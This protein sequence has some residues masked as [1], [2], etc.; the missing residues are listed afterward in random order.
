V[1]KSRIIFL[2]PYNPHDVRK[3]SGT[4]YSLYRA[5]ST[6]ADAADFKLEYVS[7]GVLDFGARLINKLVQPW[8]EFDCR[9]STAYAVVSGIYLT[10]R[11]AL[12]RDGIIVAVAASNYLPYITTRKKILYI[13]DATFCAITD[14]YSSF[15]AYPTWLKKQGN[16]NEE[17]S[18]HKAQFAIYPSLWAAD[19]A[20]EHYGVP[21]ERVLEIPFGPNISDDLIERTFKPK[22]SVGKHTVSI[23]FVS[24]D[25]PRKNGDLVVEVCERLRGRGI[26]VRLIVIGKAPDHVARLPFVDARGWLSKDEQSQL[27]QLCQAYAD[28]HLLLLP[29][30]AEAFGVVYSEAQAFGVPSISC[31]VGGVGSAIIDEQTGSVLSITA[32]ADAF[33]GA[34]ERLVSSPELYSRMSKACRERYLKQANW[35][36]WAD[37]L[38]S[39]ARSG[40]P[41]RA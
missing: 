34:V 6:R 25:W 7:G 15:R 26:Q 17:R 11:L 4:I 8:R 13:S 23:M 5:L 29:T 2:S 32:D 31:D 36:A 40:R 19:S 21:V 41:T 30:K 35:G 24:T 10:I 16:R 20:R 39:L 3:W 9:F 1:A 12:I 38:F 28:A 33:A 27:E 14:L 18:L 37:L 22:P